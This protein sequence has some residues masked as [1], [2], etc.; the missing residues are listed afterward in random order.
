[1]ISRHV[2]LL[3]IVNASGR[4]E[5]TVLSE[6]LEV[7]QVTIRKDVAL[8]EQ[9]G[10]LKREHGFAVMIS[11]DDISNRLAFN[12]DLKRK[13]AVLAANLV[14]NGETVMIESGSCCAL[15]AQEL[16]TNKR[17]V[18]I[19]TNSAFIASYIRECPYGKVVLL[20][21]DYQNESQVVVGPITRKC[22]ESFYVDKLFVGTDGFTEKAGF[23]GKNHMRSETVRAMAENSNKVIVLTESIKFDRQGVV[24]QFKTNEVST[25]VTDNKIS[26][27]VKDILLENNIDVQIVCMEVK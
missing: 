8:L 26:E 1:M 22:V 16:A 3:E 23:T 17:D 12:Y 15:L 25:L 27:H 10:L 7:S 13:I 20:G 2:N 9:K 6:K 24:A 11:S 5:V 21:G 4:I 18:T 19:I 14:E